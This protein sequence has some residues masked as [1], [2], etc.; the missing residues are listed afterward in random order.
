MDQVKGVLTLQG[1]ALTQAVSGFHTI[2]KTKSAL[3]MNG[4]ALLLAFLKCVILVYSTKHLYVR[5]WSAK[6][7]C[8][9]VYLSSVITFAIIR[10]DIKWE[11]FFFFA[12]YQH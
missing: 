3:S 11:F 1:E 10:I 9:A 4:T 2:M 8:N 7:L 5:Q 12:G 6:T